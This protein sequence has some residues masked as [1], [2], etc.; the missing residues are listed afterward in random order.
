[1]AALLAALTPTKEAT[2]EAALVSAQAPREH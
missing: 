2:A 1:M